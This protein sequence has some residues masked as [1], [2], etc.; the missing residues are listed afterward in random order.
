MSTLVSCLLST[1]KFGLLQKHGKLVINPPVWNK[2]LRI[3]KT[4]QY[5]F[6]DAHWLLIVYMVTVD[7][8]YVQ[9]FFVTSP[10]MQWKG[11][12]WETFL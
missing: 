8:S 1:G 3:D 11:L 10:T 12:Q 2:L 5:T 4:D 9:I 6:K 7:I